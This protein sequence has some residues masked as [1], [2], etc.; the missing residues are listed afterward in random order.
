MLPVV[1]CSVTVQSSTTA[2]EANHGVV[3]GRIEELYCGMLTLLGGDL[4]MRLV[5]LVAEEQ[6]AVLTDSANPHVSGS[7]SSLQQPNFDLESFPFNGLVG[8]A[9]I[10]TT[11]DASIDW[12]GLTRK[13]GNRLILSWGSEEQHHIHRFRISVLFCHAVAVWPD[14]IRSTTIINSS[15]V[16]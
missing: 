4:Q 8:R 5:W 13:S 10:T 15:A 14:L 7:S 1:R 6:G 2:K 3:N 16:K 12:Y 9:G 11:F